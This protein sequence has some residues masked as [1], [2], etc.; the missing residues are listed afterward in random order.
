MVVRRGSVPVDWAVVPG[1]VV[2]TV[3]VVVVEV[4]LGLVVVPVRPGL[5]VVVGV[6]D[7]GISA[8]DETP[9]SVV[10][11]EGLDWVELLVVG[12]GGPAGLLSS[13]LGGWFRA[14]ATTTATTAVP[15]PVAATA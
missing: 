10:V 1:L 6:V 2:L 13:C 11:G 4:E 15:V 7:A 12:I 9:G 3:V 5:V 8:D 14:K